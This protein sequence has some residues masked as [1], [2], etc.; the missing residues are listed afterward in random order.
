MTISGIPLHPLVVHAA[1][2]L[3]PLAAL[4][5]I[6]FAVRPNWRWALRHP[7]ALVAVGAAAAVQ[8]SAI[9]GD[10][11]SASLGRNDPS[12]ALIEVHEMWAG[13]LQAAAWVLAVVAVAAWW[14]VPHGSPIPGHEREHPQL[15][16]AVALSRVAV[17][18]LF[19][20]GTA[21]G[22]LTVLTGHA[23]AVAVWSGQ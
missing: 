8:F 11:L 23:G 22:I 6:L 19:V 5:G 18:L 2:F 17:P 20:L 13:R 9:T 12:R 7:L 14:S 3:A 16:G 4:L 10:A 1:V 21:T 15:A